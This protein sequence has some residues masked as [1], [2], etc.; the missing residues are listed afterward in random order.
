MAVLYR[1]ATFELDPAQ[2]SLRKSGQR[3]DVSGR[4]FDALH[5]MVADAGALITKDRFHRDVW[6]GIAVTDEALTQCVRSLRKALGD[7]AA[8]PRFIETVQ[9]H[10]YRFV[11]PVE[12][13]CA[14]APTSASSRRAIY[15]TVAATALGGATAGILGGIFYVS[16]GLIRAGLGASS[17]MLGFISLCLALGFLGGASIGLGTALGGRST[18][19]RLTSATIGGLLIGGFASLVG[20]DLFALL[21]GRAPA[22]FTGAPEAAVLGLAVGLCGIVAQGRGTGLRALALA[23]LVGALAGAGIAAAGGQLL[24]ASLVELT[25]SFP[26]SPLRFAELSSRSLTA[27]TMAEAALFCTCCAA[28]MLFGARLQ[29]PQGLLSARS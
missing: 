21:F 13:V 4:Y 5:L 18:V 11:A 2:R 25:H 22:T 17:T 29:F 9:R 24:A 6:N 3:L 12:A 20:R 1:F 16:I 8:A 19:G 28:A 27:A 15:P 10:G 23:P 26:E 14:A 7:E